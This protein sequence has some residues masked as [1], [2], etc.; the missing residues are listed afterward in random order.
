MQI[1]TSED[2]PKRSTLQDLVSPAEWNKKMAELAA[3]IRPQ[4]PIIFVCGPKSAGKSTFGKLLGNRIITNRTASYKQ[5]WRSLAVLDLDPGQPEYAAPGVVSL[6]R[7]SQP[8]LSPSFCHPH[9]ASS[10]FRTI[11]SHAIAS[12]SP[13]LDPEHYVRCALDLF[14]QYLENLDA[15]TP[16]II[17]TPGWVQ[18]TGLDVISTLIEKMRPSEVVYMSLDGPGETVDA[19][20]TACKEVPLSLLPSQPTDYSPRT[21]LQ[22]RTMQT[23][24]YFHSSASSDGQ[25]GWDSRPLTEIPPWTVKFRG[26]DRGFLGVL[27]Y[28]YQPPPNF[29]ADAINGTVVGITVVERR[30]AL[31]DLNLSES[32]E[33]NSDV[34]EE[35]DTFTEVDGGQTS[36]WQD[37]VVLR[38]PGGIPLLPNP[39]G[40]TLDPRHSQLAGLALIRG[41]DFQRG[42]LQILHP[43]ADDVIAELSD[44]AKDLI[45]VAGKFDTPNWVYTEDLYK[46]SSQ[47][48]ER[49]STCQEAA[50]TEIDEED[51]DSDS[52][53]QVDDDIEEAGAKTPWV[54]LLHGNQKRSVGSRV[55]RVRRDLGKG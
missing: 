16:L 4:T 5:A 30:E 52:S 22:F 39:N 3:T 41:I 40:R 6:V 55:W 33:S 50:E 9:P 37:Q 25:P 14:Q 23:M 21:A 54:E 53:S 43:L 51:T 12:V 26:A 19:L 10:G 42:K 35:N 32:Q 18:G 48:A 15:E 31:R 36:G 17:N 46:M 47:D 45:L 28:D 29:L 38:A 13:A 49:K 44:K 11:R 1:Y 8:T 2:G 20:R 7:L 24:S 27:C 34:D